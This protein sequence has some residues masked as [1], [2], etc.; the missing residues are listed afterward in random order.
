MQTFASRQVTSSPPPHLLLPLEIG[1]RRLS[2]T[3][4][5][6]LLVN[7]QM[8]C[9]TGE[10]MSVPV[11]ASRKALHY[12][13]RNLQKKGQRVGEQRVV[14]TVVS[15]RPSLEISINIYWLR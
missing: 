12:F 10:Q 5:T 4:V 14:M 8:L 11:R 3:L 1:Q 13:W 6:T 15:F 7:P 2:R 9:F